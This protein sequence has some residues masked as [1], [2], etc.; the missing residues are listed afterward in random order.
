MSAAYNYTGATSD[1]PSRG[2][3]DKESNADS[4]T[5]PVHQQPMTEKPAQSW[6]K[7]MMSRNGRRI[8]RPSMR[9]GQFTFYREAS[10]SGSMEEVDEATVGAA[11]GHVT[12]D[13][14][15]E[16]YDYSY[17]R[18]APPA[19]IPEPMYYGMRQRTF[20]LL[21]LA[22]VALIAILAIALGVGLGVGLKHNNGGSADPDKPAAETA[23]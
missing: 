1:V 5:L 14:Q 11:A 23:R 19:P 18:V 9:G 6:R 12:R 13:H 2:S 10:P 7:S 22:A 20:R 15:H 16:P 17:D 21:L 4:A 3:D 8:S